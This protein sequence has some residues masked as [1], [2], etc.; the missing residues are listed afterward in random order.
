[1]VTEAV[2]LTEETTEVV[3]ETGQDGSWLS[4]GAH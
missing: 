2:S 1:M 4:S 3:D